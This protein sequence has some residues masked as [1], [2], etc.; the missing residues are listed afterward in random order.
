MLSTFLPHPLPAQCPP[1]Q[2]VGLLVHVGGDVDSSLVLLHKLQEFG[3]VQ[4][5]IAVIKALQG[6]RDGEMGE[7][8]IYG[9]KVPLSL[10]FF[11]RYLVFLKCWL[12]HP[13]FAQRTQRAAAKS[14]HQHQK[15]ERWLWPPAR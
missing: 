12:H 6:E 7:D 14:P 4:A 9:S 13:C 2:L 8:L 10:P 3:R 1:E 11:H 5:G 15:G